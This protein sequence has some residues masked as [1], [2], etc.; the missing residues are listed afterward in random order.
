M[1]MKWLLCLMAVGNVSFASFDYPPNLKTETGS[2]AEQPKCC[3]CHTSCQGGNAISRKFG[4]AMQNQ[5]LKGNT[6]LDLLKTAINA[7]KTAGTDS[8]GDG[9]IDYDEIKNGTD[10]NVV[11]MPMGSDAGTGGGAD[12]GTTG[13]PTDPGFGCNASALPVL[14][15]ALATAVL[16]RR[17]K[18]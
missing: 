2:A 9:V 8:D 17:K 7:L 12:G 11:D 6:Q 4:I 13:K 18:S 1:K 10:P 16:A 15:G 5:G 3:V 14:F